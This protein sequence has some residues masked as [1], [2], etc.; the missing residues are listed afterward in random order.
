M[1][2]QAGFEPTTPAFGGQYSIQLSYWCS[3]GA[4]ILTWVRGVQLRSARNANHPAPPVC[5]R[6]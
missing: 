5:G 1:V 3:A 6:Q 4:M 2:H